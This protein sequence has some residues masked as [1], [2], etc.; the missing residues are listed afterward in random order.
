M[1]YLR[2]RQ[3]RVRSNNRR[4]VSTGWSPPLT[5]PPSACSELWTADDTLI[6]ADS[7]LLSADATIRPC[8]DLWTASN[9]TIKA[10][11]S[12]KTVDALTL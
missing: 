4:L 10:D 12:L 3:R 1:S 2:D 5:L 11:S 9:T 6:T 8:A 7:T